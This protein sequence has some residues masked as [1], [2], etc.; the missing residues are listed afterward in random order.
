MVATF[1]RIMATVDTTF[2]A[3]SSFSAVSPPRH[4]VLFLEDDGLL[5]ARVLPKYGQRRKRRR[6]RQLDS[7]EHFLCAAPDPLCRP[8]SGTADDVSCSEENGPHETK[9]L[10]I[11]DVSG[12]DVAG[13]CSGVVDRATS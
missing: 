4:R 3:P 11:V 2:L 6:A 13:D 12:T 8:N 10:L 7:D 5:T 1:F 9:P